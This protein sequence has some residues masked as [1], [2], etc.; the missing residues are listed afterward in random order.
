M[1]EPIET[2]RSEHS[3]S[4]R[5]E[6]LSRAI[7]RIRGRRDYP[8]ADESMRWVLKFSRADLS[9]FSAGDWLNLQHEL[10]AFSF[11]THP[12]LEKLKEILSHCSVSI[13]PLPSHETVSH[14]QTE[15]RRHV[16]EILDNRFTTILQES[17]PSLEVWIVG[18]VGKRLYSAT[19]RP[20][21]RGA[22]LGQ[23]KGQTLEVAHQYT[24]YSLFLLTGDRLRRCDE[25]RSPFVADRV[26]QE[27]CSKACLSRV[28]TR[29]Y[30][31]KQPKSKRRPGRPRKAKK[32]QQPTSNHT[33]PRRGS[34]GTKRR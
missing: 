2:Y 12:I 23:I 26:D 15:T 21:P 7:D 28:T 9:A 13:P 34:Y 22:A 5:L 17:P 29:R 8:A 18:P 1:S 6:E 32:L 14:L 10:V 11:M 20:L 31:D 33:L 16:V 4:F 3:E 30:R 24:M 19:G 25:C 27:Y